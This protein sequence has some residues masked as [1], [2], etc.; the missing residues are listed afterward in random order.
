MLK[1]IKHEPEQVH[2]APFGP[3]IAQ[4]GS[5][6][7]WEAS[8]MPHGPKNAPKIQKVQKHMFFQVW[9]PRGPMGP[10]WPVVA[11]ANI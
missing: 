8:G 9:G 11:V 5:H 1:N 2:M 4:D 10:Y 7:L 6:W 3:I